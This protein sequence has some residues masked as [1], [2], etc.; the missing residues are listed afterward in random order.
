M[1]FDS[2]DQQFHINDIVEL[3]KAHACGANAWQIE[4]LGSEVL[5]NCVH[6]AHRIKL[7]RAV[8][9]SRYRS[10]KLKADEVQE[11]KLCIVFLSEEGTRL[12]PLAASLAHSVFKDS[13]ELYY[14][15]LRPSAGFDKAVERYLQEVYH[16]PLFQQDSIPGPKFI[17]ELKPDIVVDL[18]GKS[19][20]Q[21]KGRYKD[22][23]RI[24][25]PGAAPQVKP[26]SEWKK[27]H[28]ASRL[29]EDHII[30]LAQLVS[31]LQAR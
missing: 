29:M 25:D 23:W 19:I 12:A 10:T 24:A 26:C 7:S 2:A 18:C 1:A 14:A 16:L 3:K 22:R 15:G 27:Y 9:I 31:Q 4:R 28:E 17:K 6:C 11:K 21:V 8:F 30:R 13:V 20:A 5:L